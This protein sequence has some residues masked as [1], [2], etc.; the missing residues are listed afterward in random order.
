M[1]LCQ[2][3]K[4]HFNDWKILNSIIF[5]LLSIP[6]CYSIVTESMT[7][8]EIGIN[9]KEAASGFLILLGTI[10]IVLIYFCLAND[11]DEIIKMVNEIEI[12]V[13]QSIFFIF[14]F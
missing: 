7:V 3:P 9:F 10:Q 8:Y 14:F 4:F 2:K 1:N 12:V 11:N 13:N 6:L 5:I